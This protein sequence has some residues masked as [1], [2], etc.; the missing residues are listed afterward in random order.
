M[1][2]SHPRPFWIDASGVRADD[3]FDLAKEEGVWYYSVLRR[4]AE[5][6]CA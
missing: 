1:L 2:K 3:R 6:D 4:A 5:V